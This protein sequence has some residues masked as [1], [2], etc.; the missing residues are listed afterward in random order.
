MISAL[1]VRREELQA[2]QPPSYF[3]PRV[4]HSPQRNYQH[5]QEIISISIL[6]AVKLLSIKG[7]I[8]PYSKGQTVIVLR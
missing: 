8:S 7:I 5:L 1:V 6:T 3:Q 4:T 2:I